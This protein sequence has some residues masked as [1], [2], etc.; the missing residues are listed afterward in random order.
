MKK[1]NKPLFVRCESK[2]YVF[3]YNFVNCYFTFCERRG[4]DKT[5]ILIYKNF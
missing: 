4:Y 3:Q 5:K 2:N 1:Y